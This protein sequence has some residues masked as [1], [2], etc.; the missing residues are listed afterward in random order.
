[1]ERVVSAAHSVA[2]LRSLWRYNFAVDVGPYREGF[3]GVA[4]GRWYAM[5]GEA[6]MLMCTWPWAPYDPSGR[7]QA[8]LGLGITSE[9][10]LN[11]CMTGFEYQVAAH[12]MAEGLVHEALSVTRA[13]HERYAAERRNPWNEVECGD[14]YARA[15]ASY[16]VF[17]TACGFDYHGPN[18]SLTMDPKLGAEDF[19]AAVVLAEGWGSY[20][21]RHTG[22][23]L[24]ATL[25]LRHGRA[26]LETLCLRPVP[27]RG[28]TSVELHRGGTVHACTY[29]PRDDGLLCVDLGRELVLDSSGEPGLRVVVRQS[30][31]RHVR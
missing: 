20:T 2:A 17:I 14:H 23:G 13:I 7:K 27:G 9:G 31:G 26:P 8:D 19:K 1:M 30:G 6:G 24:D 18:R 15:M 4:G 3:T 10:Y 11:E 16:G 21:Q 12:M 22:E 5:P 29:L 28:V 25:K